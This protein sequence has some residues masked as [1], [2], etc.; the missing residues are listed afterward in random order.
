METSK[1]QWQECH[2]GGELSKFGSCPKSSWELDVTDAAAMGWWRHPEMIKGPHF[3]VIRGGQETLL[4]EGPSIES[5][6]LSAEPPGLESIS[7]SSVVDH[8]VEYVPLLEYSRSILDSA[9]CAAYNV[10]LDSNQ[11]HNFEEVLDEMKWKCSKPLLQTLVLLV[12]MVNCR[13]GLSA[14]RWVR[15]YFV[16]A[17]IQYDE[18]SQFIGLLAKHSCPSENFI[19]KEMMSVGRHMEG[20][21]AGKDMVLVDFAMPSAPVGLIPDFVYGEYEEENFNSWMQMLYRSV[22]KV[23]APRKLEYRFISPEYYAAIV[24]KRMQELGSNT[25]DFPR[26]QCAPKTLMSKVR[27]SASF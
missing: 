14:A 20:P 21:S 8:N 2:R 18:N 6:T 13:I 11:K 7:L 1:Y 24:K 15:K 16:P 22:G 27:R 26:G 12:A 9:F 3:R 23:V 10:R 4:T 19:A 5:K 25:A 17:V